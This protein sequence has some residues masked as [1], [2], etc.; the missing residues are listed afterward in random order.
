MFP[1]LTSDLSRP[2]EKLLDLV[3]E[4]RCQVQ[5]GARSHEDRAAELKKPSRIAIR[6]RLGLLCTRPEIPVTP[7]RLAPSPRLDLLPRCYSAVLSALA[8]AQK[9]AQY[10]RVCF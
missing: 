7:S 1:A 3:L 4:E 8:V 2:V 6:C 10:F 9:D 5:G